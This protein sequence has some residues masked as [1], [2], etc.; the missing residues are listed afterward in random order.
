VGLDLLGLR[1]RRP[2]RV[3]VLALIL[4]GDDVVAQF[5]ALVANVD[6]RPGD[7]LADLTL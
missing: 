1:D 2:T 3:V 5:D 6:R 4:F 7:E